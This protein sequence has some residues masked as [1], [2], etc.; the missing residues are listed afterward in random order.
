[1]TEQHASTYA[2]SPIGYIHSPYRQKF[3]I[4]RQPNLAPVVGHIRFC[5]GIDVAAC[6]HGLDMFS[7]LW[8]LFVFHQTQDR[9]WKSRVKAPRLGGN[10]TLGVFASRSTHRPNAVGMSVVRQRGLVKHDNTLLLEVEGI[11][12]LDGTP[13]IDI[14]P[15]LP[16][17]DSVPSATDQLSQDYPHVM[18]EV[19]FSAEASQQL[20]ALS[21]SAPALTAELAAILAQDPRPAYR[22]SLDSDERTYYVALYDIDIAWRVMDA[23]VEVLQLKRIG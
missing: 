8:L 22:Q 19:V 12:L 14:K 7:H 15:Y 2:I 3:A 21:R 17:A 6:C 16:Y 20:Q 5:E 1:M 23:R 10:Q 11:D 9:G 4:P 18:R 13:I